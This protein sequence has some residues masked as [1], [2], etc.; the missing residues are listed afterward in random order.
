M[1]IVLGREK[2]GKR[3]QLILGGNIFIISKAARFFPGKKKKQTNIKLVANSKSRL[4]T[5]I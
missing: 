1:H 4:C 3:L 5:F 2:D